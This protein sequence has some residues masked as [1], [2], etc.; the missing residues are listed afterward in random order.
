[1]NSN[2]RTYHV[3]GRATSECASATE[4]SSYSHNQVVKIVQESGQYDCTIQIGIDDCHNEVNLYPGDVYRL[5]AAL[6]ADS[7]HEFTR[8]GRIFGEQPVN[9]D[10]REEEVKDVRCGIRPYDNH[11]LEI[12]LGESPTMGAEAVLTP[13][14]RTDFKRV[15]ESFEN[16][17]D[18]FTPLFD[19]GIPQRVTADGNLTPLADTVETS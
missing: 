9:S 1:M 16:D 7:Y 12:Q 17:Q 18:G 2:I 19:N 15:I 13:K 14:Q 11:G 5:N 10:Y 3:V 6:Q 4:A 8:P